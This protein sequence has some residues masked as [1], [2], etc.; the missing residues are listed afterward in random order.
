MKKTITMNWSKSTKGTHV[1][2]SD[3][4]D[5]PVS[6]IYI[7]RSSLPSEAPQ[8]INLTIEYSDESD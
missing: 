7:K 4:D 3:E 5:T 1:Y 6:S 2:S 8:N